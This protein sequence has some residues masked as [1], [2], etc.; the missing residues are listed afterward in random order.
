MLKTVF[1]IYEG[2]DMVDAFTGSL[3]EDNL[4]LVFT[5]EGAG[6]YEKGK[7]FLQHLKQA[8]ADNGVGKLAD[9]EMLIDNK[10]R[11][12]DLTVGFSLAAGYLKENIFYLK[13][14]NQGKVYIRRRN[15]FTCLIDGARS[16]SGYV[17]PRD[18]F[19]FTTSRFIEL[20][21]G[22]NVLKN[23]MKQSLPADILGELTPRLKAQNDEGAIAIFAVMA[24]LDKPATIPLVGLVSRPVQNKKKLITLLLVGIILA[25]FIWSVGLGY[26]RRQQLEQS[27]KIEKAKSIIT[28]KLNQADEAAFLNLSQALNSIADAKTEFETLKA[29]IDGKKY[30]ESLKE[31][32]TLISRQEGKILKREEKKYEEFYD[33]TI[34]NKN[35]QGSQLAL[36]ADKLVILD[37]R[38]KTL[39]AL[40]LDKKSLDKNTDPVI[41]DSRLI[42]IYEDKTYFFVD[43]KGIFQI[44]GDKPKKVIDNDS[45]W[46]KPEALIL[47]NGNI[48]LLDKGKDEIYKYLSGDNA[49]LKKSSYFKPEEG[50]SLQDA[51]SLAIDSALYIGFNDR[52]VKYTSGVRDEFKTSYPNNEFVL[53]KIYT[54]KDLDKVYVLDKGKS[55]LYVLGKSGAYEKEINSSVFGKAGDFVVYGGNAYVLIRNKIYRVGLN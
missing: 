9:L 15:Q 35:A 11:E 12:V 18:A 8:I 47:Y 39:Y 20:V 5:L 23:A 53:D 32:Q 45:D 21:G 7:E 3:A 26:Q 6:V 28:Q 46:N 31:I 36:Y 27:E 50:V 17:D 44:E 1:S 2:H 10:I 30:A 13:T 51:N 29:A 55:S 37:K 52:I 34:D 24:P 22:E 49:F 42:G 40:S 38:Q 48:Y 41:G 25:I 19:I 14:I 43:G 16:A 54:D 4:F 33:L